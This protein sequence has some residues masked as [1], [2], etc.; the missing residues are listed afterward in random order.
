MSQKIKRR[1]YFIKKN[2]QGK[3]ILGSFLLVI[4]SIVLF[5]VILGMFST[6]SMTITYENNNLQIGQTP[7]MLLKNALAANWLFIIFG[8]SLLVIAALLVSHHIAGPQFRFEKALKNMTD[9]DLSDTIYLRN[10]DEGTTLATHINSFNRQLS[11]KIREIEENAQAIDE[12]ITLLGQE[13]GHS[14]EQD[15][16]LESYTS[17]RKHNNAIRSVATS[18]TLVD[19]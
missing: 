2:F 11:K 13:D 10:K 12:L 3:L 15:S 6:D 18:F 8:G 16:L 14:V 5:T 1:N 9:G 4:G 7:V 19:E 17:I